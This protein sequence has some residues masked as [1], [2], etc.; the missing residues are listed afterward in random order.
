MRDKTVEF[1]F[2]LTED[3]FKQL[4][5][6]SEKTGLSKAKVLRYLI[7]GC[8]LAE[9]PPADYHKL[10]REI[11]AV[12]NNLNQTLVIAKSNGILNVPDLKQEILDLRE[13]EKQLREVF[14]MKKYGNG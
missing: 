3:N 7:R 4:S 10:I 13:I 8:H 2:L 5:E 12:G 9:A 6:L 1:H 14:Q 11:R